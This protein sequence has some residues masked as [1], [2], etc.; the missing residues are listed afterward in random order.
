MCGW[1]AS[2]LLEILEGARLFLSSSHGSPLPLPPRVPSSREDS[3]CLP[4]TQQEDKG[5]ERGTDTKTNSENQKHGW[6]FKRWV[7]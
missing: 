1:P 5:S 4:S 2:L 6:L 7:I 3:A